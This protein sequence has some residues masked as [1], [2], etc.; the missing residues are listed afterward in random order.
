MKLLHLLPVH[1][2]AEIYFK[3]MYFFPL[4]IQYFRNK[5]NMLD[6]ENATL[7]CKHFTQLGYKMI[8]N[9][10]MTMMEYAMIL[11]YWSNEQ[12]FKCWH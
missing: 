3:Q 5:A 1:Y 8:L 9:K 2:L 10:E 11:N 7:H 12:Y 6:G 4:H